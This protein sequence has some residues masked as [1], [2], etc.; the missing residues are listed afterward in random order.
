MRKLVWTEAPV[1][2]SNQL[3]EFGKLKRLK[4]VEMP[5]AWP[6]TVDMLIVDEF[7]R[8]TF[9][10][11]IFNWPPLPGLRIFSP[12][13]SVCLVLRDFLKVHHHLQSP[14]M[15][16]IESEKLAV[17]SEFVKVHDDLQSLPLSPTWCHPALHNLRRM[18][19]LR[20]LVLNS[21]F[22]GFVFFLNSPIQ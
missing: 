14:Q 10:R 16:S 8:R 4:Q 20:Q 3:T 2:F 18:T 1:R 19:A 21:F 5:T 6:Q 7:A 22:R 11:K 15:S 12:V 9:C 13:G 17:T